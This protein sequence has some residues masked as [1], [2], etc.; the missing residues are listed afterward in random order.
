[1]FI[2]VY[3]IF[4]ILNTSCHFKYSWA[5]KMAQ[6]IKSA[7]HAKH[8][9]LSEPRTHIKD[10]KRKHSISCPFSTFYIHTKHTLSLVLPPRHYT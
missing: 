2:S 9:H 3:L 4:N 8:D 6:Q 5:R 10:R 1:M 7:C